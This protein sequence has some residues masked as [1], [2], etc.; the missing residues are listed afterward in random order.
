LPRYYKRTGIILLALGAITVLIYLFVIQMAPLIAFG[1]SAIILGTTYIALDRTI[2][3]L[4]PGDLLT[5][6]RLILVMSVTFIVINTILILSRQNDIGIYFSVQAICYL[7][8][9]Y[10]Y[11]GIHKSASLALSIVSAL[12]IFGFV[13]IVILKVVDILK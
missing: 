9:V 5:L 1:F 13:L 7:I 4:T 2:F 10:I 6:P 3:S 11:L 12:V 8:I